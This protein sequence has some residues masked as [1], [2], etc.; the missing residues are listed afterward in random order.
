MIAL[1]LDNQVKQS[2][3]LRWW[4]QSRY[5]NRLFLRLVNESLEDLQ[6]MPQYNSVINKLSHGRINTLRTSYPR[7][8]RKLRKH[9]LASQS[10]FLQ[11]LSALY[12]DDLVE[13]QTYY[14]KAHNELTHM[15]YILM[16]H[17]ANTWLT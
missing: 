2:A 11:C 3:L 6:T 1:H 16:V 17:G 5:Q 13:A 9:L 14:E 15:R 8:A 10:H 4:Q 12:R 7:S